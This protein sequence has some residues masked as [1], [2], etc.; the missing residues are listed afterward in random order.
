LLAL[1][2][3][4]VYFAE[5]HDS[6][7]FAV[8]VGDARRYDAWAR[9]IV[10][11]DWLG[12]GVFYQAPLYPYFLALVYKLAGPSTWTIRL[13]QA[14]AGAAACVFLALAGKRFFSP[15][16]G[17]LTGSMLALYPPA[18][19]FD[20]LLQ[21]ASLG[22]LFLTVL[23]YVLSEVESGRRSTWLFAG[24]AMGGLIL[25]RENAMVL[26]P[27]VA[28]W[29]V[30]E[31]RRLGIAKIVERVALLSL[32]VALFLV[33]VGLRNQA[34]GGGFLITTSQAGSNFFIGNNLE[35]N[36][37][38]RPLRSHGG[39][40]R[41]ERFDAKELAEASEGRSLSA[42]E[43]SD[44]WFGRATAY[45]RSH[46]TH[47]LR[48]M[49]GKWLLVWNAAEIVDTDSIEAYGD[50]SRLLATLSASWHFGFLAPLALAGVWLTK[51]RWRRL[52]L[53][54]AMLLTVAASVALFYVVARYRYPLTPLLMLF[55]AAAI[56]EG[57]TLLKQR[58]LSALA[59]AVVVLLVAGIVTNWPLA[60]AG[61]IDS[62]A[63]NY[64]N[65]GVTLSA[66]GDPGAAIPQLEQAITLAPNFAPAYEALGRALT[67]V[68]RP[69]E[70]IP[71]FE[72]VLDVEPRNA[73]AHN[74]LAHLMI[75]TGRLD[76]AA[77]HL[78]QALEIDPEL[79]FAHN[80]LANIAAS[81]GELEE[82]EVEYRRA[83]ETDPDLADAHYKLG[84]L[85][86]LRN[87]AKA[88]LH[89]SEASRL[90]PDFAEAHF[91]LAVVL[92]RLARSSEAGAAYRRV[93]ALEPKHPG[94]TAGLERLLRS[95]APDRDVSSVKD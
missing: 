43:V 79:G 75:Q 14:S 64:L 19:F 39:D 32:G 94:A 15:R 2:V 48:L 12:S 46:P 66:E 91:S 13:L 25:L 29:L 22:L 36:G 85:L 20:G 21:K 68:D 18:M 77:S 76:D 7:F 90:L 74:Q 41:V 71:H 55:A 33:P 95:E 6:P 4:A 23:L 24:L 1:A 69:T 93:L 34:V 57:H 87:D 50:S 44:Y 59:A 31:S 26:V 83:L 72:S 10:A 88:A 51:S 82:A 54:Y 27:V 11:G 61:G 3:R 52:W 70:A 40:A 37:R 86:S 56:I 47:W 38:Y 60:A 9:E 58:R 62:R 67:R 81:R 53:L 42:D 63:T 80:Q 17:W 28:L 16:T 45:I 5:L 73:E 49:L 78:R 35:A 84:R 89:L 8:L 65:L 30:V 92:E